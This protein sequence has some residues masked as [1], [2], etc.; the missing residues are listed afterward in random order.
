LEAIELT[1][2]VKSFQ[3]QSTTTTAHR[4]PSLQSFPN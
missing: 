2:S 4:T 1:L 3:D